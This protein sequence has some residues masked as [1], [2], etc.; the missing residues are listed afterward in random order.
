MEATRAR[1]SHFS[2]LSSF[3]GVTNPQSNKYPGVPSIK[4]KSKESRVETWIRKASFGVGG[5]H[6]FSTTLLRVTGQMGQNITTRSGTRTK[7]CENY[8]QTFRI[9]RHLTNEFTGPYSQLL[10][11]R[12]A[13]L[14]SREDDESD[15]ALFQVRVMNYYSVMVYIPPDPTGSSTEPVFKFSADH[16]NYSDLT[17]KDP[18]QQ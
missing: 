16:P 13:V 15:Q 18:Q 12:Y 17:S 14:K 5:C 3:N 11:S 7:T 1:V 6:H 2:V 8:Y 9:C 10:P 4:S